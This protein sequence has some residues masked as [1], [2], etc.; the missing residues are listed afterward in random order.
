MSHQCDSFD[1]VPTSIKTQQSISS[2]AFWNLQPPFSAGLKE[3]KPVDPPLTTRQT[4]LWFSIACTTGNN[5]E[6]IS[7]FAI[8]DDFLM[9]FCFTPGTSGKDGK[10]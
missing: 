4:C 9:R 3:V 5:G 6:P 8:S 7:P 2:P 10:H 1:W